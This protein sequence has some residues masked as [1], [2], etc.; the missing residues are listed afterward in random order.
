M[1]EETMDDKFTVERYMQPHPATINVN[2]TL[3]DAVR[4]MIEKK[5][6]GLVVINKKKKV[7]GIL[8]GWDTIQ[9]IVPNYLEE[10]LHLAPF[11][12]ADLFAD[13]IHDLSDHPITSFMTDKVHTVSISDPLMEAATLLSEFHIR[14]LPVVDEKGILIG[15]INRTDIK[16]AIG[17]VL[18]IKEQKNNKNK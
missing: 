2:A 13:R 7:V 10:D 18:N 12:S 4:T 3:E 5:T 14:Q 16:K 15:Y 17:D 11:E 8:S 6:N 1:P 9:Y